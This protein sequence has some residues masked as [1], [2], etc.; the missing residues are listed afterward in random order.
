MAV[1]AGEWVFLSGQIP[2]DPKTGNLVEGSIEDQTRRVLENI[3][4]ILGLQKLSMNNVVKTTL[5]LVDLGDF[6]RVNK[7][8]AEYFPENPPARS[9]VQVVK[10]P[11][12][13]GLEIEAIAWR[14]TA[15]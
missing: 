11:K 4:A 15:F 2:I 1:R 12:G 10:L 3:R 5:F 9:T 13:A 14:Q 6:D 7:V 8:Y